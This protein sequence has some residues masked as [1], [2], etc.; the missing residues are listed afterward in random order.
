MVASS[1]RQQSTSR[2]AEF[3][4]IRVGVRTPEVSERVAAEAYAEGAV[5]LEERAGEGAF[6]GGVVLYDGDRSVGFGDRMYAVPIRAL[7][8]E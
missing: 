3:A 4:R 1:G 8:E 6:A 2:S 5:G 7:W